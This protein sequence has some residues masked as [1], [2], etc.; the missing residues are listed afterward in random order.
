[1]LVDDPF[2]HKNQDIVEDLKKIT[3]HVRFKNV[4][5]F[6]QS[7]AFASL[8]HLAHVLYVQGLCS[9]G[10]SSSLA[11]QKIGE[12][13]ESKLCLLCCLLITFA[14]S[15]DPVKALKK[16]ANDKKITKNFPAYKELKAYICD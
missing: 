15:L 13:I 9:G 4:N 1:M 10:Y 16:T 8:N 2:I 11:I 6:V 5:I 12:M 3:N 14:N 7:V